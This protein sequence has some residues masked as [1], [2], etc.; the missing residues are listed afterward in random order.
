MDKSRTENVPC[1]FSAKQNGNGGFFI[2][3]EPHTRIQALPERCVLTLDL[4]KPKS[5]EE[6]QKVEDFLNANIFGLNITFY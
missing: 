2:S 1:S 5:R 6:A 3:I 4:V